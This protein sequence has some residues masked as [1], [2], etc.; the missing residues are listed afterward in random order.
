MSNYMVAVLPW[1]ITMVANAGG[2]V[3]LAMNHF[4]ST[5]K[6]LDTIIARL[7]NLSERISRLEGRFDVQSDSHFRT[8]I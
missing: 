1:I 6:R 2:F 3:W 8:K 7:D 4:R 5:N